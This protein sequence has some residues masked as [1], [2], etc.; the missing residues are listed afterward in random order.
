MTVVVLDSNIYISALLFGGNPRTVIELA[1]IGLFRIAVSE[2]IQAEVER[3]LTGKFSWPR[4]KAREAE[5]RIWSR[6]LHVSPHLT[7]TDCADPDDNRILECALTA[8]AAVI[9]TGDDHLLKLHPYQGIA[10]L[11][12]KQFLA[13]KA[14]P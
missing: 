2:P 1:E 10:I 3:V 11:N 5:A 7:V 13:V 9:V 12:P 4:Q 8:D 14:G 6:A